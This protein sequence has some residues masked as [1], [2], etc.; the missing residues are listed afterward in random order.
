MGVR[1][2]RHETRSLHVGQGKTVS[3]YTMSDT[4]A[5]LDAA[6][7]SINYQTLESFRD[8]LYGA[9]DVVWPASLALARLVAH[10]PSLVKAG[11]GRPALP[12]HFIF[13]SWLF[14]RVRSSC[15]MLRGFRL[16]EPRRGVCNACAVP[17]S[18]SIFDDERGVKS[19]GEVG[20]HVGYEYTNTSLGEGQESAGGGQRARA[21]GQRGGGR[22]FRSI[23]SSLHRD[24]HID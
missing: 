6:A 14:I 22:G 19:T 3:L 10:C 11:E 7:D 13:I 8:E 12:F 4:V 16:Y 2:T 21:C 15:C 24:T 5:D 9:G 18:Q 20:S 17:Y 1:C 23:R